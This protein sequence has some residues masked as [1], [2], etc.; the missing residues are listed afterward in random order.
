MA[1]NPNPLAGIPDFMRPANAQTKVVSAPP[2]Q[3]GAGN[4]TADV[5]STNPTQIEVRNPA[6]FTPAV[7]THEADHVF[8]LSRNPGVTQ[9]PGAQKLAMSAAGTPAMYDYGGPDGLIA[10]RAAGKTIA[11][12]TPEQQATMA[13]DFQLHT[14]DAIKRGDRVGLAK[15]TAAY[16]PFIGQ[17]ARL[18]GKSESMTTMTPQNLSPLA[19]SVPPVT[20]AGMPMQGS[21]LIGDQAQ[22]QYVNT[23]QKHFQPAA[24]QAKAVGL[25]PLTTTR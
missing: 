23:M 21:K 19:P 3:V 7:A 1:T 15:V 16:E 25:P 22:Q 13:S 5:D 10:A 14:N 4:V 11:D 8:Q 18:P 24:K 2:M 9:N 12:F 17:Q 6:A 20:V